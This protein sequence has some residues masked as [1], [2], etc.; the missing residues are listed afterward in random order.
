MAEQ[1]RGEG[2]EG[3]GRAAPLTYNS[4][5]NNRTFIS[6]LQNN[7]GYVAD[8]YGLILSHGFH[9]CLITILNR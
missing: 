8:H 7:K 6:T 3:E 4:A 2:G 5:Q 1:R 9:R